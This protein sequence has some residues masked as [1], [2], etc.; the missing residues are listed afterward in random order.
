MR[1]GRGEAGE[2][3]DEP[4]DGNGGLGGVAEIAAGDDLIAVTAAVAD[5][6]HV[7]RLSQ[8]GHDAL[9]GPLGEADRG[10]DVADADVRVACDQGEYKGVVGEEGPRA[11]PVGGVGHGPLPPGCG[12]ASGAGL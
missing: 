9:S 5:T 4:L 3:I 11:W 6:A 12:P 1:I 2:Q 8:L 10:G 7:A